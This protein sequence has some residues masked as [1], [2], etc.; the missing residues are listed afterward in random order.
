MVRILFVE[1]EIDIVKFMV[2]FL[3]ARGY[4]IIP[5]A[6]GKD[7]VALLQDDIFDLAIIDLILPD[8]NGNE[9]CAMI[10]HNKKTKRLPIIVSTG[11][12]D[13][14]TQKISKDIGVNEF[15]FKPYTADK[16]CVAIESCLGDYK[17]R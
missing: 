12:G 8:M 16:L 6:T 15:L 17:E 1:D 2:D 10:R 4:Q 5:A 3:F 11:I 7:A 9:L 14:F 13:A